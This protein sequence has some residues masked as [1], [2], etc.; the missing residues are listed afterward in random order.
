MVD[1]NKSKK[2]VYVSHKILGQLYD[3]INEF[4]NINDSQ[5]GYFNDFHFYDED[6]CIQN[7]ESFAFVGFYFFKDYYLE[8]LNL[9]KNNEIKCESVL[10]TGNNMDND[11]SVFSKKK[12]N[13]DIREKVTEMMVNLFNKFNQYFL[14]GLKFFFGNEKLYDLNKESLFQNNLNAFASSCYMV[15]YNLLD[16]LNKINEFKDNFTHSIK[17]SLIKDYDYNDICNITEY[18]C[19]NFGFDYLEDLYYNYDF[20]LNTIYEKIELI[21]R[22]INIKYIELERFYNSFKYSDYKLINNPNEEN[23]YRIL[24]FP[25][26]ISGRILSSIKKLSDCFISENK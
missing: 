1:K 23:I 18:E 2:K 3:K 16:V 26:C 5:K 25:W 15:S 21:D 17:N 24:S 13:Y 9:M 10:L 14:N 20:Y 19:N 11:E 7:W 12:H 8:L 6:L 4:I 22:I